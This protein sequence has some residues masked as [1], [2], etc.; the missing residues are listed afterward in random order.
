MGSEAGAVPASDRSLIERARSGDQAAF[1]ALVGPLIDPGYQLAIAMLRQREAA[2]DA[3]QEATLRAWRKFGQ[4][5]E[6]TT[7]LRPWFLAIV[8]NECRTVRRGRWW[9]VVRLAEVDPP[10][11]AP[12]D[13]RGDAAEDLRRSVERLRHRDRLLLHLHY[14]LDLPLE[15]VAAV[16]GTTPGAAKARRRRLLHRLRLDLDPEEVS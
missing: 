3:V 10:A 2:E 7:S 14:W 15:E 5:R 12:P 13:D 11:A 6:G 1:Q 9:A 16:L 4:V 8:A